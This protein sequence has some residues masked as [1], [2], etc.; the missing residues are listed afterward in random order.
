LQSFRKQNEKQS[1]L[2]ASKD[3]G[4][5][6]QIQQASA[7]RDVVE[8]TTQVATPGETESDDQIAFREA[9]EKGFLTDAEQTYFAHVGLF[10]G[11][12]RS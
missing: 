6:V 11:E 5:F 7:Y 10:S 12:S 4:A 2:L 9:M 3:L 1:D 8:N